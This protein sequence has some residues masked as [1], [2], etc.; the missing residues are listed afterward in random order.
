MMVSWRRII[1]HTGVRELGKTTY[2]DNCGLIQ[3]TSSKL[4]MPGPRSLDDSMTGMK[5]HCIVGY[6]KAKA[7]ISPPQGRRVRHG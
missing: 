2:L 1:T 7:R 3:G 4:E 5:L 6:E